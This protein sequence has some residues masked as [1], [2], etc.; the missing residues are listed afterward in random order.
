MD[1]LEASYYEEYQEFGHLDSVDLEQL[2]REFYYN[3]I[4]I[5]E[6]DY[7]EDLG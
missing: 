7:F 4:D 3:N 1:Y 5:P 6:E 2:A